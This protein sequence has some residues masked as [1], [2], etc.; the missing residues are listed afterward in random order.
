MADFEIAFNRTLSHEGG[1]VNDPE[2]AGGET[3]KGVARNANPN[4]KG[5]AIIDNLKKDV[6]NFPKNLDS[7]SAL[8]S[9]LKELYKQ[10][11][12]DI[13]KLDSVVDQSIGNE[14]FDTG[15]NMGIKIAAKF[16]QEAL[17]LLNRNEKNY[18]DLIE[19]GVI[20]NISLGI[21]NSH[22]KPKSVFKTMNGL[23]FMRYVKICKNNPSQEKYF[24]G[25]LTRT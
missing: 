20:G 2:D 23:Q 1:Y 5:W 24:N 17:N 6:V 12:W 3:Y 11:Y 16:I 25:W 8:Q 10:K 15:I 14:T 21:L 13:N 22:P 18:P 9:H 4:W 19:D 7:D